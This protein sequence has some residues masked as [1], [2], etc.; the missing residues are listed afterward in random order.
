VLR[1]LIGRQ[2]TGTWLAGFLGLICQR[3]LAGATAC[4]VAQPLT[5]PPAHICTGSSAILEGNA[6][7]NSK[8]CEMNLAHACKASSGNV[9]L[10]SQVRGHTRKEHQLWL[11][12]AHAT[13]LSS[14]QHVYLQAFFV[15]TSPNGN[16]CEQIRPALH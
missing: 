16:A 3:R 9:M 4:T 1:R 14:I 7:M 10:C 13:P 5:A 8:C 12:N 11:C 2:K 6:C 15:P